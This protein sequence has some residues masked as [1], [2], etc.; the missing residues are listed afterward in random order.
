MIKY[1]FYQNWI[2]K[3]LIL[4][5]IFCEFL[6]SKILDYEKYNL[7]FFNLHIKK[8]KLV[9]S[10]FHNMI[11]SMITIL[12]NLNILSKEEKEKINNYFSIKPIDYKVL[13]WNCPF[14]K[15]KNLIQMKNTT[16]N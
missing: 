4:E 12:S 9:I 7:Y 3:Y 8:Y 6:T 14:G 1:I 15:N 5:K 10:E 16:F 11:D 13:I 2:R